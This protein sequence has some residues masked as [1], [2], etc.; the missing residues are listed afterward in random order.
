MTRFL[1]YLIMAVVFLLPAS[2]DMTAQTAD[3]LLRKSANAIKGANGLTATFTMISGGEKVTG[4][5]KSS[6]SR[7]SLESSVSSTWY[8]GKTMW[9]YNA[10]TNETTMMHPTPAELAES[11]PLYIVNTYAGNFTAEYAKSQVKGSKTIILTP[12]SKKIGYKSVYLTIPDSG[13]FPSQITI[14]PMS[15]QRIT[16]SITGVKTGQRFPA[17]A[18]MYPKSKY[19]KAE[20]VDLR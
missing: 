13:S 3:A 17:N 4:T 6:G 18:F 7:F 15:G 16:I 11:N 9:T 10:S 1:K 14:N 19:P 8:D 12:K 5:M 20:I 2:A